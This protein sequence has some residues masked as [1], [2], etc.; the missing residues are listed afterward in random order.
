MSHPHPPAIDGRVDRANTVVLTTAVVL[1]AT[2]AWVGVP[3]LASLCEAVLTTFEAEPTVGVSR[4]FAV[5]YWAFVLIGVAG[6]ALLLAKDRCFASRRWAL[7][8]N[9]ACCI[10]ILLVGALLIAAISSHIYMLM[11]ALN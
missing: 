10:G 7:V 4:L 1:L 9:I 2:F 6:S 11:V 3:L 8:T 5:P